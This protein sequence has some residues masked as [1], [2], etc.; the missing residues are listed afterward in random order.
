MRPLKYKQ[1]YATFIHQGSAWPGRGTIYSYSTE[2][3]RTRSGYDMNMAIKKFFIT[4]LPLL[5]G[6]FSFAQ[7]DTAIRI[8]KDSLEFHNP[9]AGYK[10][11]AAN[12]DLKGNGIKIFLVGRNY[13]KEWIEPVSVHVLDMNSEQGGLTPKKEGGGKETRSLQVED[14]AGHDW[15]LRSIKKYPTNAL[16]PELR[17]TLGEKIVTD[18]ISASYPYGALSMGILSNAAGVPYLKDRLAYIPDD[19]RLGEYRDKYKNSLVLMEERE[20]IAYI[21]SKGGDDKM[22]SISTEELVYKLADKNSNRVDQRAVLRARLLDNFVMDFDRHEGQWNWLGFDSGKYKQFSPIPKDR[23][24]VFYTNQGLLPK[25]MR[26]KE[27][28]PE[29]QGFKAQVEHMNTFNR[30][31]RNFDRTFLTELS[32]ADWSEEVDQFLKNVTDSVIDAALAAQPKEVQKYAASSIAETLKKKRKYFRTDMMRYYHTLAT[33]V[34]IVGT[35]EKELFHIVKGNEG[36]VTLTVSALDS[37]GNS[38]YEF[39]HR[40]F[41][42]SE[43]KELRLYGLE[44]DDQFIVEGGPSKIKIRMVGGPGEDQFL[45][46]GE[47]KKLIAYDV[48]FEKNKVENGIRNRLKDDPMNNEYRRLGYNYKVVGVGPTAEISPI[49]GFFLGAKFKIM[50]RGFRKDSFSIRNVIT[51]AHALNSSSI[52]LHYNG[53][54]IKIAGRTDLLIRADMMVPTNET[55]FF[56]YGNSTLIDEAKNKKDYYDVSY[57]IGNVS[58]LLKH[59]LANWLSVSYG[60]SFQ[61]LHLRTKENNSRFIG[62]YLDPSGT[63]TIYKPKYYGGGEVGLVADARNSTFMP[64]RGIVLNAYA[65]VLKGMNSYSNDVTQTGGSITFYT[66]FI[67]KGNVVLATIFGG[68]HNWGNFEFEQAQY[69]GFNDHLRGYRAQRF[70]G[71]SAAYNNTEL[72]IKIADINAYLFPAAIGIYGF[73]DLGKVWM[74]R[75][76]TK[77]WHNG[78]GGGLWIAP[79]NRLV[80][81][82]YLSFSREEKALPWATI[83]FVF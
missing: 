33:T 67:S 59:N 3:G 27:R 78:Y 74:D 13:R 41:Q 70:A 12:P 48:S 16:A 30:T 11:V 56:G 58:I 63:G 38:S 66:D 68:G 39:Y 4:A 8:K 64:T 6:F 43:T 7:A 25:I 53:D 45:N 19:P 21:K 65:R 49:E 75:E 60:P 23:D 83:G 29:L 80:V 35:N 24:Q 69:L 2:Y 79:L 62:G 57:D 76:Q 26:G 10:V 50:T 9:S 46:K 52:H 61:Y 40:V 73:N 31:A 22:E 17:N 54:F 44:D 55:E 37:A 82:G 15:A 81:T 42:P 18:D 14:A 47:G 77:S 51:A 32:E 72:R 1:F 20:P 28:L 36:S 5:W 34:S 71:R